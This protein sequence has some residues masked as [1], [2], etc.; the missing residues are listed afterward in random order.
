MIGVA[1]REQVTSRVPEETKRE[2]ERFK[3]QR[4]YG[5]QSDAAREVIE[6]GLSELGYLS[7][8]AGITP[9]RR[10]ARHV[11]MVLF[12]VSLTMAL[13]SIIAPVML[14]FPAIG[15]MGGSVVVAVV[16]QWVLKHIEPAVTNK[17]PRVEVSR[18]GPA[19]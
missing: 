11:S 19:Q 10:I 2:I 9:A 1:V 14:L 3:D 5:T 8:G 7:D 6:V 12:Y 17:L 13:I 4:G 16:D 18:R 15:V